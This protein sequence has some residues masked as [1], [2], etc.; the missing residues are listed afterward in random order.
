MS[1]IDLDRL[2]TLAEAAT[3]L[4]WKP[5]DLYSL[6]SPTQIDGYAFPKDR[7]DAK[8]Q[9]DADRAYIAAACNATPALI[10]RVKEAEAREKQEIDWNRKRTDEFTG[11]LANAVTSAEAELVLIRARAEAAERRC[12]EME[13]ENRQVM[14]ALDRIRLERL[15]AW[16]RGDRLRDGIKAAPHDSQCPVYF[17]DAKP[18]NC[19]QAALLNPPTTEEEA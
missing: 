15:A 3:P 10:E 11:T 17:G 18:C 8:A 9:I 13:A 6:V 7:E 1:H 4:P 16:E 5:S 2:A 19:W 12:A 14:D